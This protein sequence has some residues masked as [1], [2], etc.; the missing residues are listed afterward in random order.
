MNKF[1]LSQV[2]DHTNLYAFATSQDIIKLCEEAKKHN[3]ASVCI[4]PCWVKLASK[5]L[6]ENKVKVCTVIGFPLGANSIDTKTFESQKAVEDGATE[7]DM[8]INVGKAKD[9][10]FKYIESEISGIRKVIPQN[11]I[12]KII[13]ET[14]FLDDNQ[15]IEVC[16]IAKNSGADFVKTSTGFGTGGATTHDIQLMRSVVG[17]DFGVKASGGIRNLEAA[18]NLINM[19]ANRLGCSASIDIVNS[20]E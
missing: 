13:L 1:E 11:I 17:N 8:V 20:C 5:L 9:G 10:D 15:K 19:G 6:S 16:K 7:L 12:L 3:F 2:I 4:N 14:C 18:L